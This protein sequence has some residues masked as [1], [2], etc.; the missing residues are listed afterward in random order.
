MAEIYR[1]P[2]IS[3][4]MEV[5]T[6]VEWRLKEGASFEAGAVVADVGTDKATMEAEVFDDGV[7]LKHLVGEGDEI[8]PGAP[9]AI[10]G[11]SADED[12]AGLVAEA[13]AELAAGNST[14]APAASPEPAAAAPV[15]P[16]P[17]AT[18]TPAPAAAP[19]PKAEPR[20]WMGKT[21]SANFSDPPG[22][23]RAVS[24]A[25]RIVASPLARAVA[26]DK[27]IDL[28]RVS[29]TGP[30]GRIVREDV[31][32]AASAPAASIGFSVPADQTVKLTPMRKTIARR[33]LE[34]HQDIPTFF[35]TISLDVDDMVATRAQLK[36]LLPDVKISYNDMLIAAVAR[37]LREHPEVNASW[38]DN[39]II[40]HGAVDIGVAVALPEGLIT[41]VLR[42]AD[43][44]RLADIATNVRELA[45]RA[46]S[47]GLSPDEYTGATFTISNLGMFDIQHFTAIINPPA[48]AI[49]AVGGI[50]QVPVVKD[51]EL[52]IGW[53][54][55]VT[56]TC[57]HRVIDGAVGA[58]FLKTLRKYTEHPSLLLT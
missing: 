46:K 57:D 7:M 1:M 52:T 44:L 4:T 31:E 8:P 56:M 17:A 12:I 36:T 39:G 43:N 42:H 48:S 3:P 15:T 33:L 29:G 9:M 55:N 45:G 13:M 21:L 50:A 11:E 25:Q 14:D 40:Q 41:P 23:L 18:P 6:I 22:D 58:A 53:R 54:M 20:S 10:L 27:G 47:G 34:S 35:L 24:T 37:S 38:T 30:G 32:A 5:G 16:A 51:G 28:K 19:P 2:A 49:L 26:A